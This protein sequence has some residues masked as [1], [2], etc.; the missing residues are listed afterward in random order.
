MKAGGEYIRKG[1]LLK[2]IDYTPVYKAEE[3]EEITRSA[4][5]GKVFLYQIE[6][7]NASS[8]AP[9]TINVFVETGFY[10]Y[11]SYSGN[12]TYW[13]LS[14]WIFAIGT[15]LSMIAIMILYPIL[16][17]NLRAN[18]ASVATLLAA[19]SVFLLYFTRHISL[20]INSDLATPGAEKTF[21]FLLILAM[22]VYSFFYLISRLPGK[23]RLLALPGVLAGSGLLLLSGI[24]VFSKHCVHPMRISY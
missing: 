12:T 20:L 17:G 21:V 19:L 7:L 6:R 5:P 10:P 18:F 16:K 24:T 14:I 8:F 15:F 23:W 13:A 9:E 2:K 1:D 3:V 22:L 4:Q 11:L